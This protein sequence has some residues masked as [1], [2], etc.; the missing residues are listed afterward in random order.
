VTIA[1][2][3]LK[4]IR[5]PDFGPH[6]E[7]T[8]L[9]AVG[10][11]AGE[12]VIFSMERLANGKGEYDD[13]HRVLPEVLSALESMKRCHPDWFDQTY[14]HYRDRLFRGAV[15]ERE[16][17]TASA[18]DG[19]TKLINGWSRVAYASSAPIDSPAHRTIR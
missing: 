15:S 19:W 12:L 10:K 1:S 11:D 2:S 4:G 3:L 18:R 9:S 5:E 13:P 6:D 16:P 7:K 17:L 14:A 8:D